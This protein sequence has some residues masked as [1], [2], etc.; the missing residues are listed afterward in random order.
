MPSLT[1]RVYEHSHLLSFL[2][3]II[4]IFFSLSRITG[5]A[6]FHTSEVFV[7]FY[8]YFTLYTYYLYCSISSYR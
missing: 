5:I 2:L 6:S 1:A 7:A 3:F 8:L 4:C